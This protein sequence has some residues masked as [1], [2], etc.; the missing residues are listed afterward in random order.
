MYQIYQAI[1]AYLLEDFHQARAS[2]ENYGN[3][4]LKDLEALSKKNA[5]F[6]KGYQQFL[7]R[8]L[9]RP[10]Q[11]HL[12]DSRL[13]YHIGESH[14]LSYAHQKI[15]LNNKEHKITPL[16][17][18]GGKAFHFSKKGSNKFKEIT[19]QN[20]RSV[21]KKSQIFVSFGEIDCRANE[22]FLHASERSQHSIENI[23][24]NTVKSYV[25]WFEEQNK[26]YNHTLY[27]FN[28]PAPVYNHNIDS[29]LNSNVAKAVSLFNTEL[30]NQVKICGLGLLDVY[31]YTVD[32]NGFSN[33]LFHIDKYHL[34]NY[35]LPEIEKQIYTKN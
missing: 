7:Q 35:L 16:I 4:N 15:K 3:C 20:L 9:I 5:I 6:C 8:L 19:K 25:K 12:S 2:L 17:T 26:Y 18:F 1:E 23:I 32:I 24:V 10:I 22:G 30:K 31:K 21:P 28:V 14:C 34:G 33:E 29:N 11:S 27:F 13:V